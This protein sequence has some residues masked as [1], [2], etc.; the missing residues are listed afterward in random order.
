MPTDFDAFWAAAKKELAAV[1][2]DAQV[3]KSEKDSNDR[4]SCYMV[5]LANV[6]GKRVHGWLSVPKGNGPFPAILTVPGAGVREI[7]PDIH[8]ALLGAL[9]MS[10]I[11]HDLPVD[12]SPGVL[13]QA[14][15]GSAQK[16]L[17]HR[18]G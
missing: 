11:I 18:H 1:P 4:V 16:L 8:H 7:K 12:E 13:P 14:G 3:V 5:T 15:D 6:D 10:I 2:M 17:G 9:S